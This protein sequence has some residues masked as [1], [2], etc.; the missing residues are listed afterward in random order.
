[1]TEADMRE[2]A[3]PREELLAALLAQDLSPAEE[4]SLEEHLKGCAVCRSALE[5]DRAVSVALR[6]LP[7]PAP[8]EEGRSRAYSAVLAAMEAK[9]AASS[10]A[11]SGKSS[12]SPAQPPALQML[13]RKAPTKR[14]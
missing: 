14:S 11:S 7:L 13:A 2:E 12:A 4:R 6:A 3:C 9:A 5:G 8:S 10:P 1:G